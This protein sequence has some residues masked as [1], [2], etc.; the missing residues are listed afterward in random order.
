MI[1]A[2]NQR[3]APVTAKMHLSEDAQTYAATFERLFCEVRVEVGSD[4]SDDA[5]KLV[6]GEALA[7]WEHEPT[8]GKIMFGMYSIL[9]GDPGR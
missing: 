2:P 9:E 7:T 8:A 1:A 4:F 3:L 6:V 5:I